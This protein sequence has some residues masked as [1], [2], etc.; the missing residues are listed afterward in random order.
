MHLISSGL[1][2][3]AL[4]LPSSALPCGSLTLWRGKSSS[5]I[6][7]GRHERR[8]KIWAAAALLKAL[9]SHVETLI[10]KFAISI[11]LRTSKHPTETIFFLTL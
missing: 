10:V 6:R 9:C 3:P 8:P 7:F 1:H 2:V 11:I 4:T 5:V